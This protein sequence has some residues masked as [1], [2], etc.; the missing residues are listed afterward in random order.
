MGDARWSPSGTRVGWL[1]SW[2]S[3][4]DLVIA[5]SDASTPPS[6]VSADHPVSSVG[7]WGGAGWCWLDDDRVLLAAA[8]SLAV[9][10]GLPLPPIG[11]VAW[12]AVVAVA[13]AAM[14]RHLT[15]NRQEVPA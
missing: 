12:F 10:A 2:D 15:R 8:G 6:V 14:Y 1:D 13:V 7:A 11:L 5:P 9:K 4:T 3:R